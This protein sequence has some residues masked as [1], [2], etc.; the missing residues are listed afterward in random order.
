MNAN[1]MADEIIAAMATLSAADR[2]VQL[3]VMQ[4]MCQAI[5]AHITTNAVVSV[6]GQG[7]YINGTLIAGVNPVVNA[8]GPPHTDTT[9]TG[10]VA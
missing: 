10:T 1:N 5:I 9:A 8:A 4:K 6:S 7:V 3:K 2:R